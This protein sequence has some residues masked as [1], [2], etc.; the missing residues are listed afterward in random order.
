[1]LLR[2][3]QDD[4]VS[5]KNNNKWLLHHPTESL[6]FK[7]LESTWN[8]IKNTYLGEFRNLVYGEFPNEKNNI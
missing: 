6:I 1:M 7:D 3:A 5:F 4:V 2:V 8:E